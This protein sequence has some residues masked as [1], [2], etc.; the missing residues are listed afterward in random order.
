MVFT[1]VN[2]HLGKSIAKGTAGSID[3]KGKGKN[4]TLWNTG[5]GSLTQSGARHKEISSACLGM[6]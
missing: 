3:P 2:S 1:V 4:L 5:E 6:C